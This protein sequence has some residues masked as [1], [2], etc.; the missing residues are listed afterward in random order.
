MEFKN[1]VKGQI[2][3][4]LIKTLFEGAGYRVEQLGIEE[5]FKE[6]R[7][8]DYCSYSALNLPDNLRQLPDLLV[9]DL[10]L[11]KAWMVEIKYRKR[12]D[13]FNSES[14]YK[15]L[16]SQYEH[17]PQT[18][19]VLI[20]GDA[21]SSRHQETIGVITPKS[22]ELM[23]NRLKH[24][25][26]WIWRDVEP[27]HKVFDAFTWKLAKDKTYQNTSNADLL[28]ASMVKYLRSLDDLNE[29]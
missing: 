13:K 8:L 18:H 24:D 20:R 16:S 29:F 7:H 28:A 10:S 6:L 23:P 17:W 15:T 22:L 12:L 9:T 27:L 5:I 2:T 19:T 1:I 3:Q 21:Q 25:E 14:L 26:P 11:K 4:T